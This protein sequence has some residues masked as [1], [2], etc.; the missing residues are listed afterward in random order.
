MAC[1]FNKPLLAIYRNNS[2]AF[3]SW[4]P[5]SKFNHVVFSDNVENL[6]SLN[7]NMIVTKIS[8]LISRHVKKDL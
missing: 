3:E 5:K 7:V 4:H 6:K 1:A 2:R 8:E